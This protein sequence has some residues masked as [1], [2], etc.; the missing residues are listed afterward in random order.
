MKGMAR[1]GGNSPEDLVE[2][3]GGLRGQHLVPL[4][5]VRAV[6]FSI[7]VNVAAFSAKNCSFKL[8]VKF[9]NEVWGL[10]PNKILWGG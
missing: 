4:P 10:G 3:T 2:R 1:G 6:L 5:G 8:D 7:K 9:Q